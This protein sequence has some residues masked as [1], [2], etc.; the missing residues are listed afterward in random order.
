ENDCRAV[1]QMLVDAAGFRAEDCK[2][3]FSRSATA[4]AIRQAFRQW[5]IE[6]TK[7]GDRVVFYYSGHGSQLK[8]T[9][10]EEADGMDEVLCATDFQKD[11]TGGVRDD[12]LGRWLD[13]LKDRNV[14]VLIDACHSGTMSKGLYTGQAFSKYIPSPDADAASR[15]IMWQDAAGRIRP[16]REIGQ[17]IGDG[18]DGAAKSEGGAASGAA[19][20]CGIFDDPDARYVMVTACRDSQKAEEIRVRTPKGLMR[21]GAFTWMLAAGL[22]GKADA[23]EDGTITH[24][25]AMRYVTYSLATSQYNLLQRPAM[26]CPRRLMVDEPIFG[27]LQSEL[28]R[29]KVLTV[30]DD[31]VTLNR[32][33]QHGLEKGTRVRI[34]GPDGEAEVAVEDVEQFL[35]KGRIISGAPK[36]GDAV[37]DIHASMPVAGRMGVYIN[38]SD[39]TDPDEFRDVLRRAMTVDDG[40]AIVDNAD[41]AD[42]FVRAERSNG[43]IRT[44][45]A[46]RFEAIRSRHTDPSVVLAVADLVRRLRGE[47]MLRQLGAIRREEADYDIDVQV[48]ADHQPLVARRSEER[49]Q[50]FR[51]AITPRK[52]C[53]LTVLC[54][55]SR[56][57]LTLLL[58]NKWQRDTRTRGG[59]SVTIPAPAAEFE[60]FV[61]P[62]A[63]QDVIKVVGTETPLELQG[64]NYKS[65]GDAGFAE[66][67]DAATAVR[68]LV[69]QMRAKGVR[70][71]RRRRSA[72]DDAKTAAG[73]GVGE[74]IVESVP[75]E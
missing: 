21:R 75:E 28:G 63:G 23:D 22:A 4:D 12:E 8:D 32:G 37:K 31:T 67:P 54:I 57:K 61:E 59:Q 65:I 10:G 14:T 72:E 5:L 53:Y 17:W 42:L 48:L 33:F 11:G 46:G 16:P 68:S 26:H 50:T 39:L 60:F 1:Q 30:T 70:V 15:D 36:R 56:G 52:S 47:R 38:A 74:V 40:L 6:G 35:A 41:E 9:G 24:A 69:R 7:P 51:L 49:Q 66:T 25:E 27:R 64:V 45:V 3:L 18:D 29:G 2:T 73:I 62:P 43:G 34:A 19:D 20:G 58:P 13:E 71:D 44:V 55:D